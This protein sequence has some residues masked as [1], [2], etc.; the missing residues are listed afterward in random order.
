[1]KPKDRRLERLKD[2]IAETHR[3]IHL[4]RQRPDLVD[5][6]P[7]LLDTLEKDLFR[8]TRFKAWLRL[9]IMKRVQASAMD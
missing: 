6:Q 2:R 8:W 1:M 9:R 3:W 5:L 7:D 4:L